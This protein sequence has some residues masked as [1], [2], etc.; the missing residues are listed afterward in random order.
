MEDINGAKTLSIM[1]F[2]LMTLSITTLN[3]K[4]FSITIKN[5]TLTMTL[6][7]K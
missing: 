4:T 7:T 3:I 5:V 2:N 1:T 6:H